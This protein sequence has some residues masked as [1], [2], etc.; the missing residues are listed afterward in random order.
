MSS[1]FPPPPPGLNYVAAI[2]PSLNLLL[3]D[4]I[5]S[6]FLIPIFVILLYF[7]TP[8]TRYKPIFIMNVLSIALALALG[9]INIY[10]QSRAILAKPVNP[11]LNTAFASILILAPLFSESI[12]VFRVVA[13]YPLRFMWWPK[14]IL[15][16][17]PI[18]AFKGARIANTVIFI[19]RWVQLN[20]H[21][22]NPLQTGQDAWNLPNVKIEWI[23]QFLDMSFAS[24]LFLARL[25]RGARTKRDAGLSGSSYG[26]YT[27]GSREYSI[28]SLV[29]R[30]DA[31]KTDM[32]F[33]SRIRTLFWIAA[34][35][36]VIPVLLILVQLVYIFTDSN[37]LHGTYVFFV[38]VNV[39]I[40][41]VLLATI[42]SSGMQQSSSM[43]IGIE[44]DTSDKSFVHGR[45]RSGTLVS[46]GN[47]PQFASNASLRGAV[48]PPSSRHLH[49]TADSRDELS[50]V[51]EV[52]AGRQSV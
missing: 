31:R 30:A 36:L 1:A 14:R 19:V 52:D 7:S 46:N 23:L 25:H 9:S 34:S 38:N 42:W 29:Y 35:N 43:N 44:G 50:S 15:V 2:E 4:T 33:S 51:V 37:F 10:N 18:I 12:L 16:Y 26:T 8:A 5:L 22:Y 27:G 49:L 41:G 21:A 3:L 48:G 6:S 45:E 24:A 39:Q 28:T 47:M 20:K 40:L 13:V 11:T 17:G 32:S